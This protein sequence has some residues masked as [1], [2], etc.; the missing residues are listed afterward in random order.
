M[1]KRTRASLAAIAVQSP[2]MVVALAQKTMAMAV[3]TV[4]T[5]Q[6]LSVLSTLR[7]SQQFSLPHRARQTHIHQAGVPQQL[8]RLRL[9]MVIVLL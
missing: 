9:T 3:A 5:R 1:I 6:L 8:H 2:A 4:Q 7:T